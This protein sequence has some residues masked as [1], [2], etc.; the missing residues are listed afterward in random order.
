MLLANNFLMNFQW[1]WCFDLKI[2]IFHYKIK[3]NFL[4]RATLKKVHSTMGNCWTVHSKVLSTFFV[5][6]VL[7]SMEFIISSLSCFDQENSN[8]LLIL[9][10][11]VVDALLY[12]WTM[13]D[14]RI[15]IQCYIRQSGI[16][17]LIING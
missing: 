15:F 7:L 4:C 8:I 5:K 11:E 1:F 6:L 16:D 13:T 9:Y 14:G 2:A 17:T 3:C 10:Y 12:V